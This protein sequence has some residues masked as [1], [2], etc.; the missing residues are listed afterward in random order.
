M[1]RPEPR[2]TLLVAVLAVWLTA[3]A[4]LARPAV[5]QDAPVGHADRVAEVIVTC[6][7]PVVETDGAAYRLVWSGGYAFLE[8]RLAARLLDAGVELGGGDKPALRVDLER[9]DIAFRRVGGRT[10]ERTVQAGIGYTVTRPDGTVGAA[11]VCEGSLV[12]RMDRRTAESLSDPQS[13]LTQ[14]AL[15]RTGVWS[16]F[17]EPVVLVGAT[18]IGTWLFFNL[19]SKRADG[20]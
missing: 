16:R 8:T 3:C 14:P 17:V 12:D 1:M 9:A 20:G 15:P 4:M 7:A 6:L 11:D 5:A 13:G 18:A 10:L 2:N 19:R